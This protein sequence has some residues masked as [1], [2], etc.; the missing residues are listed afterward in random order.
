MTIDY[1]CHP[2]ELAKAGVSNTTM[3]ALVIATKYSHQEIDSTVGIQTLRE[4]IPARCWRPLYRWA[5][6]YLTRD[7][8]MSAT[9]MALALTY[10][11]KVD[12]EFARYCLWASYGIVEGLLLTGV[13]VKS[14]QR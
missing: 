1:G 6:W 8:A 12:N 4:A 10:I 11:P 14:F 2:S 5:I 3:N 7:L 13:W 9:V